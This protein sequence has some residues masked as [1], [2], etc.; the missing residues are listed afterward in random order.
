MAGTRHQNTERLEQEVDKR[1][2]LSVEQV[3]ATQP[4]L[5]IVQ[6]VYINM[7]EAPLTLSNLV[8][9]DREPLAAT[10]K[11]ALKITIILSGS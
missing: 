11:R 8:S 7:V 1:T 9:F 5:Q 3:K 10:R 6:I 4:Y 2:H